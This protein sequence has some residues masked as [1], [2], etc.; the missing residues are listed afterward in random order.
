MNVLKASAGVMM[1]LILSNIAELYLF[2]FHL[3]T[4]SV[5][6][7]IACIRSDHRWNNAVVSARNVLAIQ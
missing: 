6:T 7:N 3:D 1:T 4:Y 2:F 5:L